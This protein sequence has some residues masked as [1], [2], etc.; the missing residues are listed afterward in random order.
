MIEIEESITFVTPQEMRLKD[1]EDR[2][3]EI[4][5]QLRLI[6]EFLD[7]LDKAF[8]G[9]PEALSKNRFDL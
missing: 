1:M 7:K 8:K 2:L 4:D 3:N 9:A 6:R 5:L